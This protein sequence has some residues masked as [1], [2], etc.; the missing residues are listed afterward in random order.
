M[1]TCKP[2]VEAAQFIAAESAKLGKLIAAS[3]MQADR[4]GSLTQRD[5][6]TVGA[7]PEPEPN[8]DPAQTGKRVPARPG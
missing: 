1:E 5:P 4:S 8:Q 2:P 6:G 7:I 3:A